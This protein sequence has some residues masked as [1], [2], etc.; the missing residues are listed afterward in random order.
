MFGYDD[1][2]D[3]KH[4]IQMRLNRIEGQI[5]GIQGMVERDVSCLDILDQ[6]ASVRSALKAVALM[7]VET[8][9]QECLNDSL[10]D[11]ERLNQILTSVKHLS[12]SRE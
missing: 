11:H 4:L 9:C 10:P 6:V 1:C 12:S 5:R 7:L 2:K 3:A 8:H